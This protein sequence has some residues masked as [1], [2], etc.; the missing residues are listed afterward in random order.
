MLRLIALCFAFIVS[1]AGCHSPEKVNDIEKITFSAPE[2]YEI[3]LT[4]ALVVRGVSKDSL[5]DR[6]TLPSIPNV[7][8]TPR[9]TL[10]RGQVLTMNFKGTVSALSELVFVNHPKQASKLVSIEYPRKPTLH[11]DR[12]RFGHVVFKL[13]GPIT[14]GARADREGPFISYRVVNYEGE[15]YLQILAE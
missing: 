14:L 15:S 8:A 11:D 13:D 7:N 9:K 12:T 2:A 10:D 5:V 4:E 1:N 6:K 3:N